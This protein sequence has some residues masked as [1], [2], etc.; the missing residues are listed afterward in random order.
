MLFGG[1][2]ATLRGGEQLQLKGGYTGGGGQILNDYAGLDARVYVH[3]RLF[4]QGG[5]EGGREG[6]NP[7]LRDRWVDT[8]G[9]GFQRREGGLAGLGLRGGGGDWFLRSKQNQFCSQ[10]VSDHLGGLV[11]LET[12][13][14]VNI[15][16]IWPKINPLNPAHGHPNYPQIGGCAPPFAMVGEPNR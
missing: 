6:G 8:R 16:N 12:H 11:T 4:R 5:R 3:V 10:I 13:V 1:E 7:S 15:F 9:G 14:K 2:G